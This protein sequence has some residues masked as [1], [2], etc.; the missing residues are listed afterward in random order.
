MSDFPKFEGTV[1]TPPELEADFP[2][3]PA[4]YYRESRDRGIKE[5]EAL[6]AII[7]KLRGEIKFMQNNWINPAGEE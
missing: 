3:S 5:N 6:R 7:T 2:H 4:D 1:Y